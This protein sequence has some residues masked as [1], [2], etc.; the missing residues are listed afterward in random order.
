MC[1]LASPIVYVPKWKME[2]ARTALAWPSRTRSGRDAARADAPPIQVDATSA[3]RAQS[4]QTAGW[5]R[6]RLRHGAPVERTA[7]APPWHPASGAPH[8]PSMRIGNFQGV[9][10]PIPSPAV[11][12]ERPAIPGK[13]PA[14]HLPKH[15]CSMPPLST[16]KL[17]P[18]T[19]PRRA[20]RGR[21]PRSRRFPV[22]P[23]RGRPPSAARFCCPGQRYPLR[24]AERPSRSFIRFRIAVRSDMCKSL[25]IKEIYSAP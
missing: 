11:G 10:R 4:W 14:G 22:L 25:L 21:P 13:L 2:A 1:A 5:N 17:N 16:R 8:F 9:G 19:R 12:G 23:V 6:R 15:R 24:A 18:R 3:S 20:R 7:S